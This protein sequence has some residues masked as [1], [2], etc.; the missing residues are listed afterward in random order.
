VDVG[1]LADGVGCGDPGKDLGLIGGFPGVVLL[2][3]VGEEGELFAV[4]G[5][6]GRSSAAE[7]RLAVGGVGDGIGREDTVPCSVLRGTGGGEAGEME[8]SAAAA[9][10]CPGDVLAVGGDGGGGGGLG[11]LE[12]GEEAGNAGI[13][14]GGVGL[15]Q[16]RGA[17][18][19]RG[20]SYVEDEASGLRGDHGRQAS[21]GCLLNFGRRKNKSQSEIQGCFPFNMLRV[22]MT[23][24]RIDGPAE[25]KSEFS[26]PQIAKR[27][28]NVDSPSTPCYC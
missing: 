14:G 18:E 15:G 21:T 27:S 25:K 16:C 5:P 13:F 17:E 1:E 12:G 28:I 8:L 7:A 26:T 6:D 24:T 20:Q 2:I 9:G 11:L 23:A 22:S 4:R 19:D 3:A 10:E